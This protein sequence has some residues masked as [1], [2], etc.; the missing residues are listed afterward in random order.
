MFVE[1]D[2][3]DRYPTLSQFSEPL[4]AA[5]REI[6]GRDHEISQLMAAMSRP[7]LCNAL[8]LAPPGSGKALANGTLI[9]VNDPRGY[10][11]IEKLVVGDETFDENGIPS[12]VTGVFPQ[13]AKR[14]FLVSFSD[15]T[16]LVCN[17]EHLWDVRT[18]WDRRQGNSYRTMTLREII[19]FGLKT[20][21]GRNRWSIPTGL[22]VE[23]VS[24]ELP[25][26]PYALGALIGDGALT[27]RPLVISS[28]DE[29]VVR[30]VAGYINELIPLE[31]FVASE[32]N[33]GWQFK[34]ATELGRAKK[35][36]QTDE[37][38]KVLHDGLGE[39]SLVFGHKSVDRRI[40]RRYLE[41]SREQRMELLR[42]LMDT[43]GSVAGNERAHVTFSTSG[44]GMVRDVQELLRS[45]GIRSSVTTVVRNDVVERGVEYTIHLKLRDAEKEFVFSLERHIDKI[46]RFSR[47]LRFERRYE[48]LRIVDV[49]DLGTTVEMTCIK[50]AAAS[51]L[52]QAGR[53]HI[54]THNTALV[55][56][57]MLA[58]TSRRY[59]EV[60]LTRMIAGLTNADEMAAKLKG[61]F[62]DAEKYSQDEHSQLVLFIDEFHQV[63][64]LSPAAVEA[65]KPV[66]A[67][68][69]ARGIRVIAATTY[70]EFHKFIAPN[71]PLVERLQRINLS[72]PS[73]ATTVKIL[74]GMTERYKVNHL[75]F[76]D[77][78]LEMIYE[79]TERYMPAS[80]QPRK[81]ILILDA[82]VGW[83]VHTGRDMDLSL[84]AD[85]LLESAN[86]N[87]AFRVD[88]VNIKKQLDSKVF[89]QHYATEALA[90]R[91]QLCVADLHDKTKPMASFLMAGSTGTGKTELTKQ[92]AKLLFGDDKAHLIRF[93]MSEYAEDK[94]LSLF[95][96][97]LTRQVF[98]QGHSVILLDEVEKA[99]SLVTRV[100]LQVLDDGRLSDD[101]GRQVSFLN[102]Y[103]VLTT[104]AGSEIFA[105]MAHYNVD[106]EGSG[107]EMEGKMKQIRRAITET[108]ADNKFPPELLGRIDVIVPF[109][110]LSRSTQEKIVGN[111]IKQL[112]R[113]VMS[114]HG[115]RVI[116]DERVLT[117]LI[118]DKA[119]VE[120]TAGGARAAISKL[121][122]EVTTAVA[123]FINANPKE[124][125]I[126]VDIVGEM[127]SE[128]KESL[129]SGSYVQVTAV[130]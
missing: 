86:V 32:H 124:H 61:L 57:A 14:S 90:K 84:L 46:T 50:V 80:T 39:E 123:A 35:W 114:K 71:Q 83:H 30:R 13:G 10:V 97:E 119:E 26:H 104:N 22:G 117:Y 29:A 103:L 109:Q 55:Q 38:K 95:R 89:S 28:N 2:L 102:S 130:R 120:T 113:E 15:G 18:G 33:Y 44:S 70:D 115:V 1:A 41:A 48:D 34:R 96:S 42:G 118:E 17:D 108:Q 66:L 6:V 76:D 98:N 23:R 112:M 4:R 11:E 47:E 63:V 45:L 9:P 49:R 64:Q 8:L 58:D 121:T 110:P 91:L 68:S 85:V 73:R 107:K 106:D 20:P 122:D 52:F 24:A 88:A 93:D 81:S 105:D 74:R 62:D 111:K 54:V 101:N 16:S 3:N 75:F 7:E 125:E 129:V 51:Q 87:V 37:L 77:H 94:A 127:R 43:D 92:L 72:P 56:A 78:V 21:D 65:L 82:M 19:T 67:A 59:M 12:A 69:G 40:P 100:L 60:D 5:E 126:E 79:Y 31:G 128:N 116:L 99:S 25:I 36:V 27:V 53:E